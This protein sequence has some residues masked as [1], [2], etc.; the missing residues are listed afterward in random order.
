MFEH[1]ISSDIDIKF[2]YEITEEKI[3]FRYSHVVSL[4]NNKAFL[5]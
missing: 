5:K 4:K 1:Q 3:D 2:S